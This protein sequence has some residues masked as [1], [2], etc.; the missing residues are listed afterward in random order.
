MAYL[1]TLGM[2]TAHTS[3]VSAGTVDD[4]AQFIAL[5]NELRTGLGLQPLA[6]HPE[7]HSGAEIWT[8]V[9]ANKGEL[10]HAPD[11]SAGVTV[12][13]AKLGENVGVAS[14]GQT[15][16]LFDAFVASPTHYDNLVDPDFAFVGVAV[17]YD[18]T[19]RMWTTHRFMKT[20]ETTDTTPSTVVA[21]AST[22][23][24][25][26]PATTQPTTQATQPQATSTAPAN[27]STTVPQAS[28][29]TTTAP[30]EATTGRPEISEPTPTPL[31]TDF[32]MAMVGDLAA[33][34]I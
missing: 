19:G 1:L 31:N 20:F 4:E 22:T 26:P 15:Q 18:D 12:N 30:A 9:L 21:P 23:T 10:S 6:P 7:L 27:E 8:A 33:A 29:S 34:G 32:V 16:Q 28:T 14:A 24:T 5:I 13:W 2:A 3:A 25:A 11:L 17:L